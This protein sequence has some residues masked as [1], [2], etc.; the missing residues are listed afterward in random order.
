M[1]ANIYS[2]LP[3]GAISVRKAVFMEEQGFVEEFDNIDDKAT[4]IV[5]YEGNTPIA[6]CRFFW[7]EEKQSYIVGRIA[8]IKEMRGKAIGAAVLNEAEKQIRMLNGDKL[9]LAAQVRAK[10]F[11][12]KQGY[13]AVGE[14]FL[15]E[16]CP[17]IWMCKN[18]IPVIQLKK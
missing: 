3:E 4:H 14:E 15:E 13:T 7:N 8:V 5:F 11:Y 10:N 17:H 9:Q 12:E 6:T 16:Y 1:Q 18:L 2:H